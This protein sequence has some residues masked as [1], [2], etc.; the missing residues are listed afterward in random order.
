MQAIASTYHQVIRFIGA[1]GRQEDLHGD[2]VASKKCYVSIVHNSTKA[3]QVQCVEVPNLAL[4]EDIGELAEDKAIEDLV[5]MPINED[6]SRFFLLGSSL[7]EAERKDMFQFFKN[8]I[9]VFAWTPYEMPGVDPN[10]ISHTLNVKKDSK[11]VV[12]KARCSAP[13]HAEA[14][15]EEV[16]RLLD[17]NA[18]Q[19]VQ[20]P[21][22][23]SNTVIV[24][25]KNGQRKVCVDYTNLI[26][27]CPKD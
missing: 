25:K 24:K 5:F 20:Y 22:W 11:L 9:K 15:M 8:N 26:D 21:T 2:Q 14:V 10:F 27:A 18:I 12:Q 19:E 13:E 4:L 1:N 6:G 23:L 17:A 3:K 16:N 7:S